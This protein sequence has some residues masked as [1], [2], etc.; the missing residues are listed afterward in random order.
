MRRG[1]HERGH[2]ED[3]ERVSREG[4]AK[5]DRGRAAGASSLCEDARVPVAYHLDHVI[6]YVRDLAAA[7]ADWR[8]LGFEAT[9]GGTHPHTGT[10]N[11]LVRFAD[12]TFLE[13]MTIEDRE[14]AREEAPT[15]V[16]FVELHP[17]GPMH[18]AL[19]VDDVE[20][21]ARE[22]EA[23]GIRVG[24]IW[25]GEGRR[26]SGAVARWRSFHLQEQAFPFLVQY[27]TAPTSGPSPVGLPIGGITAAIVQ[28]VSAP[29]LAERLARAFGRLGDDGRVRLATGEIAVVEEPREHPGV[30]GVELAVPDEARATR[31]LADRGVNVVDGWMGDKRLHGLAVRLVT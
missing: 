28:G 15:I 1:E 18:W 20:A 17:D 5:H 25:K 27:E 23:G 12:G 16:A 22:L 13:L 19:R 26:D 3:H 2:G 7:T 31:M 21:A 14:K 29:S 4:H 24:P 30:I 6:V 9:D 10:R 8:A 11:A